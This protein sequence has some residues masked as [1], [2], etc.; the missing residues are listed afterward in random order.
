MASNAWRSLSAG[1]WL[2]PASVPQT[3]VVSHDDIGPAGWQK[4]RIFCDQKQAN[5]RRISYKRR[6]V[7]PTQSIGHTARRCTYKRIDMQSI[8]NFRFASTTA[9]RIL[10]ASLRAARPPISQ[11]RDRYG[12][13]AR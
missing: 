5:E 9:A 2:I 4:R 7:F 10:C 12:G 6:I 8:A 13:S 11:R 1:E 3:L